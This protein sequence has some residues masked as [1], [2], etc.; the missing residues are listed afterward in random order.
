[1]QYNNNY[2]N[3]L[4]YMQSTLNNILQCIINYLWVA[5]VPNYH[6]YNI[7]CIQNFACKSIRIFEFKVV[8]IQYFECKKSLSICMQIKIHCLN[9]K[10]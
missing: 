9:A 6:N 10:C 4:K 3:L 1:M 5:R 8:C 2:V 7:F